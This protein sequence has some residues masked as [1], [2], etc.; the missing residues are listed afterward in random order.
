[1]FQR[2]RAQA[3]QAAQAAGLA[4]VWVAQMVQRRG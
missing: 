4:R 1:M 2:L 3:A